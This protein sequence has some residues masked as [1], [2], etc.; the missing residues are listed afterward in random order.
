VH[1]LPVSE[2]I[3]KV[4]LEHARAAGA[5]RVARVN[6][7]IGDLTTFVDES[8]QFYF[9]FLSR[10]TEAEGAQ[11]QIR[12]IAA[13][14]RC[15]ECATEFAPDG[16]DWDCPRCGSLGGEVLSGRESLIESIEVE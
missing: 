2:Q 5:R 7:A 15:H 16:T 6:L 3:L 8:I 11:L 10:D 4:V 12:R 13:L 14:V 1:E 9:D